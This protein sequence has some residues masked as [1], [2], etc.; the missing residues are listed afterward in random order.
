MLDTFYDGV[1]FTYRE[2]PSDFYFTFKP[3]ADP[4]AYAVTYVFSELPGFIR[5]SDCCS[6][7]MRT[8][9]GYPWAGAFWGNHN[10]RDNSQDLALA[11]SRHSRRWRTAPPS[12][13]CA[14]PRAAHS[15]PAT[16]W[17]TWCG[18]TAAGS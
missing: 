11:T 16:A 4:T 14:P 15:K 18:R 10:S 1:T 9:E 2:D 12:R 7:L 8:P 13:W 5:S 3:A 17:A 6:S